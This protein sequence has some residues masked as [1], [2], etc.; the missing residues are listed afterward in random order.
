[1]PGPTLGA[2]RP[3]GRPTLF[4]GRLLRS[5]RMQE[6]LPSLWLVIG[7]GAASG[8]LS[9]IVG[10]VLLGLPQVRVKVRHDLH[11]DT[12]GTPRVESYVAVTNVRGRPVRIDHVWI[13][14]RHAEGGPAMNRPTGWEFPVS[15]AEGE[16]VKCTFDRED[17]P[18]AV[19]VVIDSA[20]RIWPR[21][22]WL[23]VKRRALWAG[24]LV[25]W[26]WQRNG[27][28]NRQIERAV[29]RTKPISDR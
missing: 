7:I 21:R 11:I 26:P 19:A 4:P 9:S 8:L 16:V 13:L 24:G 2:L 14:K 5:A 15:L 12:T 18:N 22:R 1:M 17:Y 27:P 29:E 10:Y 23:R 3:Y 28:T 25:G 6:N 20:D